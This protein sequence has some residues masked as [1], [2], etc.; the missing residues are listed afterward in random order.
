MDGIG[1]LRCSLPAKKRKTIPVIPEA[2]QRLSGTQ[3]LQ[4][5]K[6]GK[7]ALMSR[8]LG[9]GSPRSASA[10]AGMTAKI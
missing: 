3:Q 10:P 1:G 9:P 2:A 7:A 4:G 5:A 8:L 6:L